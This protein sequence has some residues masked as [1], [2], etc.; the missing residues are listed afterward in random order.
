MT[1][2]TYDIELTPGS[3]SALGAALETAMDEARV[4]VGAPSGDVISQV[5]AGIE[6]QAADESGVGEC[7]LLTITV[8]ITTAVLGA[9]DSLP[10]SV[11][12]GEMQAD[13]DAQLAAIAQ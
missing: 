2:S 9:Q 5:V 4:R 3:P 13:L 8:T 12:T 7:R 11:E 6:Q 10:S 1:T